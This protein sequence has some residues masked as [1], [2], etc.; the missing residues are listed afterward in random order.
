MYGVMGKSV[1]VTKFLTVSG[2]DLTITDNVRA[3]HRPHTTFVSF[4]YD[5]CIIILE[6]SDSTGPISRYSNFR[7][8][9]EA[10][11]FKHKH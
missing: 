3:L 1:E 10:K 7:L 4:C 9:Q 5:P 2:A 8:P 6:W 11:I